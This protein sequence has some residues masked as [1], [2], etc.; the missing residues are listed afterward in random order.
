MGGGK[1]KR[2]D[3]RRWPWKRRRAFTMDVP[4]AGPSISDKPSG[5]WWKKSDSTNIGSTYLVGGFNH[6]EK[7]ESQWEGLSHILWKNKSHIP[8]HQLVIKRKIM[9]PSSKFGLC[10]WSSESITLLTYPTVMTMAISSNWLWI[11][12]IIYTLIHISN[13]PYIGL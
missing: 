9:E 1:P 8:N 4:S 2:S 7:Y 3:W 10:F 12:G 11:I 6:L 13:Y 5:K